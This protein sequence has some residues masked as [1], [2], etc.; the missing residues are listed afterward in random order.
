MAVA[1]VTGIPGLLIVPVIDQPQHASLLVCR[2]SALGRY[3]V[4]VQIFHSSLH[5]ACSAPCLGVDVAGLSAVKKATASQARRRLETQP[6]MQTG[7][8]LVHTALHACSC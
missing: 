7:I 6:D 1:E 5:Q 4:G 3:A 2:V 8:R